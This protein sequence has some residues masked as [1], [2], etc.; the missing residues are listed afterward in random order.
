MRSMRRVAHFRSVQLFMEEMKGFVCRTFKVNKK[1]S[2]EVLAGLARALLP[3][4]SVR[5][6]GTADS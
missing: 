5:V 4:N 1:F 3:R 6:F 2:F